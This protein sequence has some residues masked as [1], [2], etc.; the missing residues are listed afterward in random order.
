MINP[1]K[2][3]YVGIIDYYSEI[4]ITIETTPAIVIMTNQVA[5]HFSTLPP[6][7]SI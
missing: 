1:E 3:K 7:I 2:E 5:T 4:T 6:P